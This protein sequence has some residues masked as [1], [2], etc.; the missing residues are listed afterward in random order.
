M[1]AVLLSISPAHAAP[2]T[3]DEQSLLE[4]Y[5]PVL[6][7]RHQ[8]EPCGD[9]ERFL[10]VAVD[11]ILGRGDVVLRDA[12]GKVLV[13]APTAADLAGGPEDRWIDL[14]GNTLDPGCDYEQWFDSLRATP[15]IYGRVTSQDGHLVTQYWFFYVYNQWNDVHEGDWE[16]AQLDFGPVSIEQAMTDGPQTYA[17]AQHEGSEYATVGDNDAKVVRDGDHPVVFVAEGSHASFFSSSRWFGKSGATGFGCDDTRAPI[18]R[19]SPTVI[20]LPGDD[21]PTTGEFA[22]LS[23]L[24]HWGEKAPSFDNGPTG[25]VTKTQ[26]SSPV[27]WVDDEGRDSA[28][29]LP[30]ATSRATEAFCDLSATGSLLFNRLLDRP[31]LVLAGLAVVVI[32]L[33]LIVR[34]SS[35]GVLGRA[36]RA[37]RT[38]RRRLLPI[39]AL[40]LAAAAAA[41]LLQFV[42]LEWTRLGT[43]V[44]TI[45]SSSAWVL[46]LVGIIGSLAAVPF[47][48]VAAA[49]TI[50][51]GRG[52]RRRRT[53]S[54]RWSPAAGR[55]PG[56]RCCSSCSSGSR[57]WCS[58]RWPSSPAAGSSPPWPRR[59]PRPPRH[60]AAATAWCTGTP[61]G[62]WGCSSR[63][64]WSPASPPVS[65]CSCCC[66]RRL[67]SGCPARSSP[68]SAWSSCRT[69]ASCSSSSTGTWP[70]RKVTPRNTATQGV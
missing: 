39:G 42:L 56:R 55:W 1:C 19:I 7:V 63:W 60:S 59:T 25:P 3:V 29:A 62:R 61:G 40:V 32:A 6:A 4:R 28:A 41:A 47:I 33:V 52:T 9:G 43:L 48:C 26:W 57:R 20:A 2:P 44:D 45:G 12:D 14:P 49:A 51:R 68:S 31:W 38:D 58:G 8:S 67:P 11:T 18:D 50:A 65:A 10:P 64:R 17:Y 53:R 34:R 35:Q 16:M 24:G 21:V 23:Y 22:W 5:S 70:A 37:W 54:G 69:S 13:T 66:S 46:P 30:F 15:A 27:T 36:W